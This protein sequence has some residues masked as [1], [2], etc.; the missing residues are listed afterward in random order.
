MK[1]LLRFSPEIIKQPIISETVIETGVRLDIERAKVDGATGE[2]V[3]NVPEAGCRSVVDFL[4][5]RGVDVT[6]L[7]KNIVKDEDNCV[8]CGAC[9][10][11]CPVDAHKYQHDWSV[12]LEGSECVQCGACITA[13]PIGVLKLPE[14]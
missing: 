12:K 5:K 9:V 4:R 8:H 6:K 13:C 2:I 3:I 14:V 11:V 7:G 1:L 10:S